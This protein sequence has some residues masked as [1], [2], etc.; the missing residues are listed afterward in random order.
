MAWGRSSS[1]STSYGRNDYKTFTPSGLTVASPDTQVGA[2]KI[3]KAEIDC[4]CRWS[5]AKWGNLDQ[6]GP[7]GIIYNDITIKQPLDYWLLSARICITMSETASSYALD[8]RERRT[9]PA[10]ASTE[11]E[12]GKNRNRNLQIAPYYGPFSLLGPQTITSRSKTKNAEPSVGVMGMVEFGGLGTNSTVSGERRT[13]WAFKGERRT[14]RDGTT[15]RTLEWVYTGDEQDHSGGFSMHTFSTAFAFQHQGDVPVFM[16]IE[17]EGELGNTLRR[18]IQ[19][20]SSHLGTKD[21]SILTEIKFDKDF[22]FRNSLKGAAEGLDKSMQERYYESL[23]V[24]PPEAR[25]WGSEVSVS[26]AQGQEEK[27]RT[28]GSAPE[29]E[30]YDSKDVAANSQALLNI[31][32]NQSAAPASTSTEPPSYT[33]VAQPHPM[34]PEILPA[35]AP[36]EPVNK[37]TEV[38]E[39]HNVHSVKK[40]EEQDSVREVLENPTLLMVASFIAMLLDFLYP[41]SLRNTKL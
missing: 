12:D 21:K 39:K 28:I 31:F 33:K 6:N 20:F 22:S 9:V 7:A 41:A 27:K 13:Q 3:G 19:S 40:S 8:K 10:A 32:N 16:R 11:A 30:D 26:A 37:E 36:K 18:G 1:N 17:I 38:R 4:R 2:A 14:P 15:Y 35:A 34:Q 25:P 23:P 29:D 24:R 5:E